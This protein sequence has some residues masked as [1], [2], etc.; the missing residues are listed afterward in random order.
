MQLANIN[1]DTIGWG[2]TGVASGLTARTGLTDTLYRTSGDNQYLR[3]LNAQPFLSAMWCGSVTAVKAE[4]FEI[5][6]AAKTID[7][8]SSQSSRDNQDIAHLASALV[9]EDTLTGYLDNGNT[10][11]ISM[12]IA[13]ISYGDPVI[14]APRPVLAG[15]SSIRLDSTT[16][17]A[18]TL[19]GSWVTAAVTWS[20]LQPD[21]Q[22][23]IVGLG[24]WGVLDMAA[25]LSS[26]S[27]LHMGFRPGVPMGLT[28]AGGYMTYFAQPYKFKGSSP[29]AIE[30]ASLGASAEHHFNVHIV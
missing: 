7:D 6:S 5:V 22:Y 10:N 19:P 4:G 21:K 27:E 25:R 12:G 26:T 9:P 28:G 16:D 20:G 2:E 30:V 29:P 23:Q 24:G 14:Y 13:S 18:G 11:E 17:T 1:F 15:G 8:F 3:A